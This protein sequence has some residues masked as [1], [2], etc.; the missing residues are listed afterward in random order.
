MKPGGIENLP[1]CERDRKDED[2][3]YAGGFPHPHAAAEM[4]LE[5]EMCVSKEPSRA[6]LT[7]CPA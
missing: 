6:F 7:C 1:K 2:L 3:L 5:G 4:R